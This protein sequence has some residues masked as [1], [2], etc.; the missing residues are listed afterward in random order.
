VPQGRT[1]ARTGSRAASCHST[2]TASS[3][4]HAAQG[5]QWHV[6]ASREQGI[7]HSFRLAVIGNRP[8]KA[9]EELLLPLHCCLRGRSRQWTA[10]ICEIV[11]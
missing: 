10:G 4:L 8:S 9:K 11:R 6:R 7:P 5:R 1:C 3:V 2:C